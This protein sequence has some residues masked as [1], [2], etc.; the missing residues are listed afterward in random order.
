MHI[1]AILTPK[2]SAS[3]DKFAP[4]TLPEEQVVWKHYAA[5][6]IRSMNF[7]PEPLRV[8]LHFE[9]PDKA[10]VQALLDTFPMVEA[11]LFDID[12]IES[13][14]WL[15]FTAL[16]SPEAVPAPSACNFPSN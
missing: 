16:F 15:P 8:L 11:G 10:T 13:G 5:G 14:P 4:L 6:I 2:P 1:L 7:Q 12:L 3:L 9:A